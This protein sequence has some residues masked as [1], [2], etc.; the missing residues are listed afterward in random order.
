MSRT[1]SRTLLIPLL[2]STCGV[3][4]THSSKFPLDPGSY[5]DS[6]HL[7]RNRTLAFTCKVPY[8]WVDRTRSMNPDP[9]DPARGSALLAVFERPPE[10]S[11]E[12]LNPTILI[13]A[14]PIASYPGLKTAEDY[15]GPLKEVATARG[16]EPAGD[17]YE[18][19]VGSRKLLRAD[20]SRK[21]DRGTIYQS[22]LVL[23]SHRSIVS[24]TVIGGTE[25]DAAQLL[26]GLNFTSAARP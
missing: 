4:Q 12:A 13:A 11:A 1:L 14:E 23:L 21:T 5:D 19:A 26:S 15:Y 24:F 9:P 7:Y 17:P 3:A 6:T 8:G 25:E 10:A 18:F 2:I 20:F 22:T 16:L